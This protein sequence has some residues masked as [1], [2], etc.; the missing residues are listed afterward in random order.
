MIGHS[1]PNSC[2]I[3]TE[4]LKDVRCSICIGLSFP[5]I[6]GV[7]NPYLGNCRPMWNDAKYQPKFDINQYSFTFR[8]SGHSQ[9]VDKSAKLCTW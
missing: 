4:T 6:S 5:K 8:T 2:G 1:V 7:T 3:P 9:V